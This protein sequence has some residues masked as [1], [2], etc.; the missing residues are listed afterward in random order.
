M[1]HKNIVKLKGCCL[2]PPDLCLVQEFAAGGSMSRALQ[3]FKA[4]IPPDVL[5]DW[6]IQIADGM[7]YL[8]DLAV[9]TLVH[10]DLKSS[11]SKS[12][13]QIHTASD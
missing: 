10:R 8:H 5:V 13:I 12:G 7:L 6:A 2:T 1:D 9:I 11:N 3:K 4:N